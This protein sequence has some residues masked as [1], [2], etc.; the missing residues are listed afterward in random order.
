MM[1]FFLK[2]H[3]LPFFRKILHYWYA[4][5]SHH[6]KPHFQLGFTQTQQ[7]QLTFLPDNHNN[8]FPFKFIY[9]F[10]TFLWL[11]STPLS[12]L[13]NVLAWCRHQTRFRLWVLYICSSEFIPTRQD[14]ISCRTANNDGLSTCTLFCYTNKSLFAFLISL[15]IKD[16]LISNVTNMTFWF[17]LKH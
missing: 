12:T 14:V 1:F 4:G 2:I 13:S 10:Q 7:L 16:H 5:L 8:F 17:F 11:S 9:A 15:L 6:S 3:F